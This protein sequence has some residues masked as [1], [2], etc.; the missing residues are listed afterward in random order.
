VAG[1]EVDPMFDATL[2]L[3]FNILSQCPVL[4]VPS[5][6]A[7]NGVPTGVQIVG[8]TYD[9]QTVFRVG[10]AVEQVRPWGYRDAQHLPSLTAEVPA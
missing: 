7:Q 2:T 4:A 5:G 1:E 8:R 3:P 10:A 6:W 9:D